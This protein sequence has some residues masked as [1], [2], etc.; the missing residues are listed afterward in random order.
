MSSIWY[1]LI[2]IKVSCHQCLSNR[3]RNKKSEISLIR[4]ININTNMTSSAPRE[5]S[6]RTGEHTSFACFKT[7][8]TKT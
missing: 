1:V 5:L 3:I 6:V 7:I 2:I 4:F 8:N